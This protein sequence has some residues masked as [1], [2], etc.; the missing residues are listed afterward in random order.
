MEIVYDMT[1]L[2]ERRGAPV[3][4]GIDR[5]D[6]RFALHA[7]QSGRPWR[8]LVQRSGGFEWLPE[9]F[10]EELLGVLRRRWLEGLVAEAPPPPP[11]W[12]RESLASLLEKAEGY[13]LRERL[14]ARAPYAWPLFA[15]PRCSRRMIGCARRQGAAGSADRAGPTSVYWNIGHSF[16]FSAS[17]EAISRRWSEHAL[18]FVHDVIPL[19]R[20]GFSAPP[21]EGRFRRFC[22]WVGGM[23]ATL[24]TSS[25]ATAEAVRNV[26]DGGR[27]LFPESRHS[28]DVLPLPPEDRFLWAAVAGGGGPRVDEPYFLMVGGWAPRRNYELLLEIWEGWPMEDGPPPRLYRVGADGGKPPRTLRRRIRKLERGGLWRHFGG[29]GDDE[30]AG[31][32]RRAQALLFPSLAEG[33]GFPLVEA[34][35]VG[36]PV[37]ASD[38][39]VCREVAGE[40]ASFVPPDDP[41][42]WR[43][44]MRAIPASADPVRPPRADAPPR[45]DGW[46]AFFEAFSQGVG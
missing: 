12:Q 35:A 23:R 21:S 27:P 33:W 22:E 4:S 25:R 30:L 32:Y 24:L 9:R 28:V 45:F 18:V 17:A 43:R 46:G 15:A 31:F 42:A 1:R 37:L 44:A 39:P 3:A 7:R 36:T 20:P 34:G 40:R 10:A 11:G 8:P 5:V 13:R 19:A 38:L 41:E 26:T 16:R 6:L 14:R 2:V 29:I